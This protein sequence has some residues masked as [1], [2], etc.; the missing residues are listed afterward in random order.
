MEKF[1]ISYRLKMMNCTVLLP[2]LVPHERPVLPWEPGTQPPAECGRLR[3]YAVCPNLLLGY[4][5]A[6]CSSSPRVDG[7][8]LAARHLPEA[9]HRCLRL[10]GPIGIA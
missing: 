10:G 4:S 8:A 5:M 1:D 2:Q 3:W 6:N 7:A 9:P